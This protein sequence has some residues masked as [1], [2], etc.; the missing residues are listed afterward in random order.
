M[1][2]ILIKKINILLGNANNDKTDIDNEYSDILLRG[3]PPQGVLAAK[4][5]R[6]ITSLSRIR[7]AISR[8][9]TAAAL[10]SDT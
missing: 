6:L 5:L 1:M 4:S 2:I 3:Q 8:R 7:A 10:T 9:L